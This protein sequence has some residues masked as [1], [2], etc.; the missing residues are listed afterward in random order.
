MS[1]DEI[2]AEY[3]RLCQEAL[4]SYTAAL[5]SADEW[6]NRQMIGAGNKAAPSGADDASGEGQV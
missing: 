2:L 5:F 6:F 1:I 3:N 4:S